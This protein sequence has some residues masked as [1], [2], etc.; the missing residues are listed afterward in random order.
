MPIYSKVMIGFGAVLILLGII[1]WAGAG[2]E[3]RA[4]TALVAPAIAAG[5]M[6]VMGWLSSQERSAKKFGIHAGFILALVIGMTF[7]IQ[8]YRSWMK[9]D[10][11]VWAASFIMLMSVLGFVTFVVLL[12]MRP[13][14][15]ERGLVR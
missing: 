14:P 7:A 8:G 12:M 11:S 4:I 10:G 2:F 13:K 5:L 3:M 1:A 9:P 15:E 6:F